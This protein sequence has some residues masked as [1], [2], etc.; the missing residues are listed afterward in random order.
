MIELLKQPWPWY[1]SGLVISGIMLVLILF[2]KSFGFSSNLR[3]LCSMMGAGRRVAFFDFEW[4][5]QRWNLLFL[6]GA[7]IGGF[8]SSHWLDSGQPLLLSES[9]ITDLKGL[10]IAFDGKMVPLQ[11]FNW[12]FLFTLKGLFVFLGGGFLVGFGTRYAG[13]CTSG[14]AISGLSNLQLP[15]LIAVIGFFIG[16]LVMTHLIFPLLFS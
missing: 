3:T 1:V 16:G 4:K 6:L 15:S 7:I 5:A 10:G 13:G 14:H 11:L 12:Q 2:G 8:I 9:T